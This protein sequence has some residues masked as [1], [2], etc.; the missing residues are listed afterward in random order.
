MKPHRTFL[1]VV[2]LLSFTLRVS[3]QQLAAAP[4]LFPSIDF[5]TNANLASFREVSATSTCG[6]CNGGSSCSGCNNTCLYGEELP[7]PVDL[8]EG[9][10]LASG[11]VSLFFL[12]F[13][14]L[15]IFLFFSCFFN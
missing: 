10:T 5:R 7:V 2:L 14:F 12:V 4:G 8:L 1:L 11:V 15:F 3:R 9:S 13:Y 6:D